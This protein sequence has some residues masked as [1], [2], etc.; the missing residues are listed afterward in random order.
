VQTRQ[1]QEKSRLSLPARLSL[2]M[3]L[4][5][6]VSVGI[7]TA[8]MMLKQREFFFAE[9]L[10]PME[11]L[12]GYM[13]TGVEVPLLGEDTLRLN[14]AVRDAMAVD[15]VDYA[16]IIDHNRII[17]AHS[18]QTPVG[19]DFFPFA[20][21]TVVRDRRD[22]LI[23]QY[24]DDAGR[25]IYDLARPVV[26][27]DKTIGVVHVGMAA[28]YIRHRVRAGQISLLRWFLVPCLLVAAALVC[29]AV[30]AA[31][32]ILTRTSAL[33]D[34]AFVYGTGNLQ[35]TMDR[36][37]NDELGDVGLALNSMAARLGHLCNDRTQLEN[38]LQFPA[39]HR[40][41]EGPLAKGEDYAVR[42][43]VAVLVAGVKEYGP[44]AGQEKP[45]DIVVALNRYISIA[46]D[47]ISRHGGYVDKIIGDAVVGIFGVSLYREEHTVR[48]L[49]AAVELQQTLAAAGQGKKELLGNIC[50]GLSAGVVLSGNIGS[51]SRVEYSSVGESMKQA[52][53]LIS[54]GS[55]GEIILGQ[56]I[57]SRLQDLVRVEPLAPQPIIGAA[58]PLRTYRF[59]SLRESNAAG[60]IDKSS[61]EWKVVLSLQLDHQPAKKNPRNVR[62]TAA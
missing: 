33:V 59:L 28:D 43:Q 13:A 20:G 46:T 14:A 50:I 56:G 3:L 6:S 23:V 38:Y 1:L 55:S 5:F 51:H 4:L 16:F 35:H 7:P 21:G 10:R 44:D 18:A 53:A 11:S 19:R 41:L 31:R 47:I 8:C 26:S 29:F 34:A 49:R 24:A 37:E 32:R 27:Q 22:G 39:L 48:A 36:I 58:E 54:L 25:Q 40:I 61:E 2:I 9:S 45:E 42:R 30:L 52:S 60:K 12:A 62:K 15:G 17:R 57:Y